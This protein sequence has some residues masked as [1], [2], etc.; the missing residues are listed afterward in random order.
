NGSSF[1]NDKGTFDIGTGNILFTGANHFFG[2]AADGGGNQIGAVLG[3]GIITLQPSDGSAAFGDNNQ[4]QPS[5]HIASGT[6]DTLGLFV[7]GNLTV[8]QGATLTI[9]QGTSTVNGDVTVNGA[10]AKPSGNASFTFVFNGQS[11]TN[12]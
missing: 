9:S 2:S 1:D 5:L 4:F 6:I 7:G 8:D 11:F 3:T 10:V 12:N